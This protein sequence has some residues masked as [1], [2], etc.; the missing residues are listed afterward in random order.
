M[1]RGNDLTR[2]GFSCPKTAKHVLGIQTDRN[3]CDLTS[4]AKLQRDEK[5]LEKKNYQKSTWK[6]HW[7]AA[8]ERIE[9]KDKTLFGF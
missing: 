9:D 5:K 2:G 7:L 4:L 1:R 8:N 3:S 6:S